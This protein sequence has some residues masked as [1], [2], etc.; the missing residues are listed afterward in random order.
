VIFL[1]FSCLTI[2]THAQQAGIN[3]DLNSGQTG[4]SMSALQLLFLLAFIALLPSLLLVMTCFT[5]IIIALSFLRS[6]IG[7]QQAPPNQVLTG[8]ALF[9]TL[10]IMTPVIKQI[11]TDAYKPYKEHKIT[12]E[13]AI[14]NASKP[15]K[16][17]MLK[18]VYEDDL[19]LFLSLAD[20]KGQLK[21]DDYKSQESLLNLSLTVIVP[22]Y[23]ISE[24]KRAFLIGFLLYIPFLIIDIVVSSTLMSMGM[25]MLPPSM[26]SLPFKLMLF[27]LVDGWSL[28]IQS[29]IAGFR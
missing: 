15:I 2:Q 1:I 21:M 20:S 6:A 27:I 26:I 14:K 10:F 23:I 5:R 25:V 29:L 16:Q 22:A 18:Q 8:L 17:F 4:D 7:T 28:M 13:V 19:D 24:L 11:N 12:Q 3:L 9:L